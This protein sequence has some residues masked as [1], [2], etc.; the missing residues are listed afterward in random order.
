MTESMGVI[1]KRD[2]EH[3]GVTDA[4]IIRMRRLL[5]K[6]AIA[7]RED[8]TTPPAV[9]NPE[10]YKVRSVSTLVPN[11]VNGIQATQDL[12]WAALAEEQQPA[13]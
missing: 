8:G 7:L 10:L 12:Q 1:Y 4:G 2:Q 5:A 9:D 11:G 13:G 6:A 3:L